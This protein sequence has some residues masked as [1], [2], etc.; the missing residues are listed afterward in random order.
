VQAGSGLL[1]IARTNYTSGAFIVSNG[2][3]RLNSAGGSVG[4][5]CTA[6]TVAGGTLERRTPPHFRR[7]GRH[8]SPPGSTGVIHIL[9]GVTVPRTRCGS[10]TRRAR[11]HLGASDPARV[12]EHTRFAGTARSPSCVTRAGTLLTLQNKGRRQFKDKA[13]VCNLC[14]K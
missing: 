2:V 10:A 1:D 11:G 9:G 5:S 14:R 13:Y 8:V 3:L 7:R 4:A 12:C 6:V